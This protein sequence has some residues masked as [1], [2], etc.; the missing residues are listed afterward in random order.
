MPEIPQILELLLEQARKDQLVDRTELPTVTTELKDIQLRQ[1]PNG[2]IQ[3]FL[4]KNLGSEQ[5][6]SRLAIQMHRVDSTWIAVSDKWSNL[7]LDLKSTIK[8]L[9]SATATGAFAYGASSGSVSLVLILFVTS[10][11]MTLSGARRIR[12]HQDH[13]N[14]LSYFFEL[15]NSGMPLTMDGMKRTGVF[16]SPERL[17]EVLEDLEHLAIIA[18]NETTGS[19]FLRERLLVVGQDLLIEKKDLLTAL[20]AAKADDKTPDKKI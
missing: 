9:G 15:S 8:K 5:G 20:D 11:W 18:R 13:A 3:A 14:V 2:R 19:I 16:I 7:L 10:V 6:L 1:I 12:L 4:E 17:E